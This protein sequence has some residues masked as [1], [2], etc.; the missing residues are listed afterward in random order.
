MATSP[1]PDVTIIVA[2]YNRPE[3]LRLA[4]R[5]VQWQ[6][7][8]NWAVIV[9][10]D[11]CDGR[12]QMVMDEFVSDDRFLYV[13]LTHRCQEQA[14]PNSAAMHV[15]STPFLALLN[16]DDVWL[17]DHLEIALTTLGRQRANLF[18]GRAAVGRDLED[19]IGRAH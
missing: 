15:A 5:S 17:P 6:T 1:R 2:T 8:P 10:G 14:L 4:L 3:V 13:N 11:L 12:T 18:V 7:F 19:E 16:H 9:V